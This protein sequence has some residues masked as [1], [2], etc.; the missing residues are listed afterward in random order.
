MKKTL[1]IPAIVII[2]GLS[3]SGKT[4]AL[5]SLEDSGF[6]CVDN[7]P[8]ALIDSFISIVSKNKEIKKIGIGIDIREKGFLSEV[9]THRLS[10]SKVSEDRI[11]GKYAVTEKIGT[12]GS[13]IIYKG[14]HSKLNMP[15]AIKML[16]HDMA[17]DHDFLELFRNEA[18]IIAQ[19]NHPN[20][21]KVYDIEE[22]YQTVFI[23]MEYLEGIPLKNILQKMSKL[24]VAQV[25]DITM[26]VCFGLEYAHKNGIIHQDINPRNIFIQ[27]DGQVKI[28]DFGLACRRGGIDENFLFPGT[29]FY[30]PPEQIKGDPVDERADIYSLGI[31]VYEMLT[32]KRPFKGCSMKKIIDWHLHEDIQDTRTTMHDIPEELHNFLMKAIRKE[33]SERY[34]SISEILQELS[35]LGEQL[36]LTAQACFYKQDKVIGMF[37]VYQEEQQMTL[38]RL[39]EEFNKKVSQAGAML[40]ITQFEDKEK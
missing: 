39:I 36:G 29:P 12:G 17:M 28:I 16:K 34:N 25:V 6:F 2:T 33:P 3:G 19:F 22:L 21:V 18:K 10:A 31:T 13:S 9:I 26:K 15:V 14:I 11:I 1:G 38:K 32:G 23:V 37:V 27:T 8:V 4:V 20:I 35:P 7:L 24:P 40:K 30:I 5:R